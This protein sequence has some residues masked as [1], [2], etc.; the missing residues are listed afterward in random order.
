MDFQSKNFLKDISLGQIISAH[1]NRRWR[2]LKYF[3][4]RAF[5]VLCQSSAQNEKES[6]W[7]IT[8]SRL[9]FC[10]ALLRSASI[11]AIVCKSHYFTRLLHCLWWWLGWDKTEEMRTRMG[12][13]TLGVLWRRKVLMVVVMV[14][15]EEEEVMVVNLLWLWFSSPLCSTGHGL[16]PSSSPSSRPDNPPWT[17]PV[18]KSS[19]CHRTRPVRGHSYW[20]LKLSVIWTMIGLWFYLIL[21]NFFIAFTDRHQG[22]GEVLRR[23]CARAGGWK[24]HLRFCQLWTS[25]ILLGWY[26]VFGSF[27]RQLSYWDECVSSYLS[28]LSR[29]SSPTRFVLSK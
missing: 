19:E 16:P 10:S 23:R 17:C 11:A 15:E 26:L 1:G 28:H 22:S 4:P 18:L 27:K 20:L 7:S 25:N 3:V 29:F 6:K 12:M 21:H 8:F 24:C 5:G 2:V 13:M 9:A 14:E